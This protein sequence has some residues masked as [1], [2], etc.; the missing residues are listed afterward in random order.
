MPARGERKSAFT[1]E[2][3]PR[4]SGPRVMPADKAERVAIYRQT[5]WDMMENEREPTMNKIAVIDRLWDRDEGKPLNKQEQSG[6]TIVRVVT[7][8]PRADPD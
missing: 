7:G 6:E 1:A 8:V 3:A 5:L 2:T 4:H